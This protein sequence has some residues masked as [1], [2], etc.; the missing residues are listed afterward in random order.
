MRSIS[1]DEDVR[2]VSV[3]VR[4]EPSA[5]R[6]GWAGAVRDSASTAL[7]AARIDVPRYSGGDVADY[8]RASQLKPIPAKRP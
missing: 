6:L 2:E 8:T 5:A 1:D 7:R 4:V 3:I